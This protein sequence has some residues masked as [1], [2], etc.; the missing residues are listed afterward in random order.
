[1]LENVPSGSWNDLPTDNYDKWKT[2][3]RIFVDDR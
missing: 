3:R 1:M 2:I